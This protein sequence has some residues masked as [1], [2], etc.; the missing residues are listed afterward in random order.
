MFKS[1]FYLFT[2]LYIHL[3]AAH[4]LA[5]FRHVLY[6]LSHTSRPT[7]PALLVVFEIGF[8]FMSGLT[9]TTVLLFVRPC[10]AGMRGVLHHT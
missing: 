1:Y 10:V 6:H 8:C 3:G 7:S 2:G 9:W 5:L 4:H